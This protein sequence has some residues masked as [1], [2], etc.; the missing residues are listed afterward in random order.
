MLVPGERIR[1]GDDAATIRYSGNLP[2]WPNTLAYGI[3]W[4]N[5]IRGKNSG[6]LDG[7]RYFQTK[8]EGAGS[9]IKA[10]NRN[11]QLPVTFMSALINRYAGD[12][13]VHAL[14]K[15]I[16]FGLKVVEN[17]G[18]EKL[19][20]IQRNVFLL[21]NVMLDKQNIGLC[22]DLPEFNVAELLDLSY[23]L[24]HKWEDVERILRLFPQLQS[25]NLNGNR[26]SGSPKLP[27]GTRVHS[28]ML[29]DTGLSQ[30]Q[31]RL[32]VLPNVHTLCLAG[33]HLTSENC[34]LIYTK[35]LS[36][37]DLSFNNLDSIPLS[38]ASS[39]ISSLAV[40]YNN[41]RLTPGTTFPSVTSLDI[42][43]NNITEWDEI[44]HLSKV[45]PSL[46]NLRIDGC[47]LFENLLLEETTI[48]LIARLECTSSDNDRKKI[49]R[50]NGSLLTRAEIQNAE[51]YFI[52]RVKQGKLIYTNDSRWSQLLEKNGLTNTKI[53][54]LSE[55]SDKVLLQI[56]SP[57]KPVEFIMSRVFLKS[58]SVLRLK[59]VISRYLDRPIFDFEVFITD[60]NNDP[61]DKSTARYLEDDT[62]TL[63]SLGLQDDQKIFITW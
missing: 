38:I 36:S 47:P 14:E 8:I 51:L 49:R 18:F 16:A 21:K 35:G 24:L 55:L 43:D 33:N 52:S 56:F 23:N 15:S 2:S 37:L 28:L 4:D 12:D 19:N 42:R 53:I 32:L 17:Y 26:L 59:G 31:L 1:V 34:N 62:T 39:S 30:Q 63:Q 3:E 40:A 54:Q 60:S 58:N 48:N 50:L 7:V 10:S 6:T 20:T 25:I 44:D 29:A 5:P 11:I 46:E 13:N 22:P 9:F 45:F 57:T 61:Y 27:T 41:I